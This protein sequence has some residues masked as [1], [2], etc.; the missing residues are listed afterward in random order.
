MRNYATAGVEMVTTPADRQHAREDENRDTPE[1][2]LLRN[3]SLLRHDYWSDIE[4]EDLRKI[5][6]AWDDDAEIGRIVRR[7]ILEPAGKYIE[8]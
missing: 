2:K 7:A 3:L 4:L 1:K 5:V 6:L 8:D